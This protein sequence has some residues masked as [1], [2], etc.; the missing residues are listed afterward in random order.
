MSLYCQ[1]DVS[2]V[3]TGSGT[4]G[5]EG[6][7]ANQSAPESDTRRAAL[8]RPETLATV[9]SRLINKI[10]V[11]LTVH[12]TEDVLR[13]TKHLKLQL[14]PRQGLAA[15]HPGVCVCVCVRERESSK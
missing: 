15:S 4:P 13:L 3:T 5:S 6:S 2:L 12:T 9:R 14:F 11:W 10:S 8:G 7:P 1:T